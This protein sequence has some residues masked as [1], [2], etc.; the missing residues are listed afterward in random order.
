MEGG[1]H[2]VESREGRGEERQ[3]EGVTVHIAHCRA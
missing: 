2:Q 3:E 1:T